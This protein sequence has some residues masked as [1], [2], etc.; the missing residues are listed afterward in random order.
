VSCRA[1]RRPPEGL[2]LKKELQEDTMPFH[3]SAAGA[4]GEPG[5]AAFSESV[6]QAQFQRWCERW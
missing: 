3:Y 5:R 6:G 4:S 1:Q 2:I